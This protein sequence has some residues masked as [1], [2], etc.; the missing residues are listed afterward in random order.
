MSFQAFLDE[1]EKDLPSPVFL[2]YASNSFLLR[3]ALRAI[4]GMVPEKERDFNLN[5]SD[6]LLEADGKTS[7]MDVLDV[8]NTFP[9]L[10]KRRF[11]VF[12]GN[13]QRLSK[14]DLK[15]L[16][17]YTVDPA[18]SSVFVIIHEGEL[19]K[20]L[21]ERFKALKIFSLN[22]REAEIPSWIKHR[23]S[24]KG[25]EISNEV[26]DYMVGLIGPDLG[27]LSAEIEKIALLGKHKVCV[28]DI[29]E[30]IEGEGF[31]TPFDLVEALER[32]D[33]E[34]V[35]RIYRALKEKT[36]D[37]NLIGV[38]N[39]LYGRKLS[40]KGSQ[41]K[42]EYFYRVFELLNRADRDIKTSGRDFPMEYLLLRLLRL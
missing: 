13:L 29:H 41:K 14:E 40:T 27:L 4:K 19:K 7:F 30:I 10:G 16:E 2:L 33:T 20:E 35:F 25:I 32:K 11:V 28:D 26:A 1:I 5:V 24:W 23:A 3:E 12:L 38:L 42:K 9:F 8:A 6:F 15:R 37:Y 39:W 31:S 36:E 21:R 17:A 22:I 34:K 18:P